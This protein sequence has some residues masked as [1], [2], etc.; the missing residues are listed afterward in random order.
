MAAKKMR[1][2]EWVGGIASMP[3]YVTGEGPPY[4]PDGLFW[5]E[6]GGPV[7]GG[8]TTM[9]GH[10]LAEAADSLREAIEHPLRGRPRPPGRVRVASPALAEVLRRAHP[11]IEIICAPT[12]E[13]DDFLALLREKMGEDGA[14]HQTYLASGL[15]PAAVAAFFAATAGL[16]RIRPWTIVPSDHSLLS[17]TIAQLDVRDAVVATIGQLGQSFGLLLFSDLDAF[18]GYVDAVEALELGDDAALPPHVALNFER[19]TDLAPGLH[20]EI[21]SH[22]WDVAGTDALP[23]PVAIDEDLIARP[24]TARET[25]LLEAL[26]LALPP[27]LAEPIP[28]LAAWAGGA[29][30]TRTVRVRTHGGE[31]EVTVRVPPRA[32]PAREWLP[33]DLLTD[34]FELTKAAE[35]GEELDHEQR[36][37][38]EDTLIERF[39]AAPEGQ[40]S[41]D[42]QAYRL[43][44]D[45]AAEALGAT[46]ATLS[47][48][49]LRPIVFEVIPRQVSVDASAAGAIIEDLRAFY[50]FL[51]RAF[52][53]DQAGACLRVL[54]GDAVRKLEAALADPHRFGHGQGVGHGRSRGR[55]RHDH[56]RRRRGLDA[57]RADERIAGVS[58]APVRHRRASGRPSRRRDGDEEAEDQS[59]A[60]GTQAE[61][62]TRP[63]AA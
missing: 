21:I 40:T 46:I 57:L 11:T 60:D 2:P 24:P 8:T 27:V 61:P 58:P 62:V 28:L 36:R 49:D 7:V 37:E 1:G 59:R 51:Q 26:A 23:W 38:L 50:Q 5:L 6:P 55:L 3:A 18:A 47:A 9:P 53:L 35:S 48:A 15:A 44:M 13:L 56:H 30:C 19:A 52:G 17:V 16:F 41:S 31:L 63:E 20:R 14:A 10:A 54:G 4:R 25:R 32:P 43:V 22:G 42:L 29:P 12:P 34:L 45:H 33:F 39:L